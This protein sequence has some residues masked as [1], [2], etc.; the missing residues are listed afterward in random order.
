[1]IDSIRF[2]KDIRKMKV[3]IEFWFCLE[4]NV[5]IQKLFVNP[6]DH[7]IA[8]ICKI[9]SKKYV[10]FLQEIWEWSMIWIANEGN[11]VVKIDKDQALYHR[12]F[13]VKL[14]HVTWIYCAKQSYIFFWKISY[15]NGHC[16]GFLK[17]KTLLML[18]SH[19]I[20]FVSR[21]RKMLWCSNLFVGRL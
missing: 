8:G 5:V 13:L 11:F 7:T 17:S 6:P 15:Q 19:D 10:F 21:T 9:L 16:A 20:G 18:F 2:S 4:S 14:N 3:P 1:M 12:F